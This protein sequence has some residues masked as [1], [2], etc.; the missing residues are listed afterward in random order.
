VSSLCDRDATEYPD[1]SSTPWFRSHRWE[2]DGEAIS[3]ELPKDPRVSLL[4]IFAGKKGGRFAP[5]LAVIP[6]HGGTRHIKLHQ[7]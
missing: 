2:D 1:T 5:E 6:I 4:S 7:L 3:V